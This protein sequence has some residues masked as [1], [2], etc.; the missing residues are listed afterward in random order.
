MQPQDRPRDPEV[1]TFLAA[2]ETAVMADAPAGSEARAAAT[3]VFG[4]TRS[5]TGSA[6]GAASGLP[7]CAILPGCYAAARDDTRRPVAEAFAA[8]APRLR[9][10]VRTSS[11]DARF[12]EGHANAMVVGPD[13]IEAR[14]DVRIGVS[15]MAPHVDYPIHVHP[16]EEVYFSLTPGEWWNDR[17]DWADPG[18]RGLIYNPPGIRHAMRSGESPFLAIWLLPT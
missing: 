12:R 13:G 9:W 11:G 2:L 6:G 10:T 14:D 15:L 5:R 3:R 7:V 4:R 8:L 1:A 17:M 16:P 18:P